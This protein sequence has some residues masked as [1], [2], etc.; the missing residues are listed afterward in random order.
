MTLISDS[1]SLERV[2][3][4]LS[5]DCF[6]SVDTEFMRERTYYPKL[7]LVQI[8]GKN[9]AIAIDTLAPKIQLEP[10]LDLLSNDSIVKVFHACRQ[11]MEIFFNLTNKIPTPLFDTQIGAMVCGHG[12]AVSYDKLVRKLIG[13]QIDKS[14]RFTDWSHRPLSKTQLNYA[15]SDVT[16]LREVYKRLTEQL[17]ENG[18]RSWLEEEF[19]LVK[20]PRTY[21]TAPWDAWKRLKIRS[22]KPR[23]L[24]L[25]QELA[26]FR[27]IEAQRRDVP[28]NRII[29]DD[30][31]LDIAARSP[32]TPNDLAKVRNMS[33][34]DA[35]GSM[36]QGILRTVETALNMPEEKAPRLMKGRSNSG[37]QSAIV[38]LLKV[39]LK[40]KSEE[41]SVAQKLIA[42]ASDLEAIA[43]NDTADVAAL[44]GWRRDIF[45][46]DALLIKSGEIALSAY[47]NNIK[48]VKLT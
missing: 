45:G 26:A 21:T 28:R 32:T 44:R 1:T 48:I 43:A 22:G 17:K 7:C 20:D 11:D 40:L 39:L 5:K 41:H 6:I 34:R 31:L 2:C 14:S 33:Q 19:N 3:Q 47:N 8:A 36:G 10:M 25:V 46:N 16:H 30:I 15:L 18:R 27:E 12:D 13:I 23:F 37:T 24:I 29:R 4:R 38:D 42:S 9:E 35:L